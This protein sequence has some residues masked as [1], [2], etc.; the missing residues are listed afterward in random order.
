MPLY[1]NWLQCILSN[2]FMKAPDLDVE[3][4]MRAITPTPY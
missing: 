1:I 2:H 4:P 3:T